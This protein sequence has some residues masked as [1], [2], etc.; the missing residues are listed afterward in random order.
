LYLS[1]DKI[2][3][4]QGAPR[5]KTTSLRAYKRKE[6]VM[7]Q[8]IYDSVKSGQRMTIVCFVSGSGTNY[9]KIVERNPEHDY[10]VFTNRPDCGGVAIARENKHEVIALSHVPYLEEARKKYGSGKIPRNCPERVQYEQQISRLIENK[11]GRQTD[12]ICLA[13]YDQWNSDWLVD[14]YFP[15]L[16][17]VHPGDTT[18]GYDG[19]HGV[20]SAKAILAGDTTVRSTLFIVDKG[21]DTGP[22]LVQSKPLDIKQTLEKLESRGTTG[23]LEG[24]K[25]VTDFATECNITTYKGF[26]EKASNELMVMMAR[27]CSSLQDTLKVKGD[28]AIYPF[29][30]H[31]LIGQGRVAV[32][33]RSVYIDGKKMPEHG[34]RLDEHR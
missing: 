4:M 11:Y 20:P 1:Q 3:G 24:L 6:V 26:T 32:S 19:L 14:K 9:R 15:R 31:G 22:V 16:L 8:L 28:W 34:Y 17:N 18:K 2:R 33:G 13:G 30:V 21:E 7:Q 23:L 10:L 29:A 5:F 27:V 12:L 25:R